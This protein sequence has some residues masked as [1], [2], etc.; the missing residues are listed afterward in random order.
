LLKTKL[1]VVHKIWLSVIVSMSSKRVTR[2]SKKKEYT[3][4]DEY[5]CDSKGRKDSVTVVLLTLMTQKRKRNNMRGDSNMHAK[6]RGIML[7][8]NSNPVLIKRKHQATLSSTDNNHPSE[9]WPRKKSKHQII[10]DQ[11]NGMVRHSYVKIN[12]ALSDLDRAKS[13]LDH[14]HERLE[15][16]NSVNM[17]LQEKY[18]EWALHASNLSDKMGDLT[19]KISCL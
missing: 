2:S 10:I 7:P 6:N 14:C 15:A 18:N 19:N 8:S 17:F 3:C 12:S 11:L 4:Y 16:S 5:L 9:D 13:E 1:S